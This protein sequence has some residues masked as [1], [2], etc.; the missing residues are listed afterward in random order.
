[1]LQMW[2]QALKS[3]SA[4]QPVAAGPD[5]A[6]LRRL[7]AELAKGLDNAEARWEVQSA[8]LAKG[9]VDLLPQAPE[10]FLSGVAEEMDKLA[11]QETTQVPHDDSSAS[12]QRDNFRVGRGKAPSSHRSAPGEG[13]QPSAGDGS[14][15]GQQLQS[16]MKQSSSKLSESD[17][18]YDTLRA[19]Q[20]EIPPLRFGPG[21]FTDSSENKSLL[22]Q[23]AD[24][25]E[26]QTWFERI[27]R[28]RQ[29]V[30]TPDRL[31]EIVKRA[32][33]G[34]ALE[35]TKDAKR[36]A[37]AVNRSQMGDDAIRH[38]VRELNAAFDR[39]R[40]SHG[41]ALSS[42]PPRFRLSVATRRSKL[43]LDLFEAAA[44]EEMISFKLF[45]A[46]IRWDELE[47]E[48]S[49]VPFVLEIRDALIRD[50]VE[51][52]ISE[53]S[54]LR[55]P[56]T[57]NR[58]VPMW[59]R[60]LD[61]VVA[62]VILLNAVSM[63]A[64]A[65]LPWSGWFYV[66]F[67][68]T[69]FF[70]FEIAV[71][72]RISGIRRYCIGSMSMW[73]WFDV[74]VVILA[75][76]DMAA[77]FIAS[78]EQA[79]NN[80]LVF[81]VARLARLTKMM[82]LLRLLRLRIFKELALMVKGVIAG[83]RTL[84]WAIVL[85]FFVTYAIGVILRQTV[86]EDKV[87]MEDKYGTVLFH[88]MQWSMFMV[89]RCFTSDCVL[90]DGSPLVG[91]LYHLYGTF[92]LMSYC[93]S[94]IF[95]AFGIFNLIAAT[96]VE[97][98]ME[99]ARQKRQLSSEEEAA[100]VFI[101]L[102]QLILKFGGAKALDTNELRHG[103]RVKSEIMDVVGDSIPVVEG[104]DASCGDMHKISFQTGGQVTRDD[105][106]LVLEDQEVHNLLDDL[107]V[108]VADRMEL[109]DVI[110][111]DGNGN[112]EISELIL[113]ILKLRSGGADKSDMVATIL[114]IRSIQKNTNFLVD[115]LQ[116]VRDLTN[117]LHK[118]VEDPQKSRVPARG[119]QDLVS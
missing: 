46:L 58:L 38:T 90:P 76:T 40:K 110:D 60:A 43:N 107:E 24:N 91:H 85:L 112:I 63:G 93:I 50:S 11:A 103:G 25:E 41:G 70:C 27:D 35:N 59:Q 72:V 89:F 74:A 69:A 65:D 99:A 54:H 5:F 47:I 6:A 42:S 16:A 100:R 64:A 98:V 2:C 75:V 19:S 71:K 61:P 106:N 34:R 55:P 57:N 94:V 45:C 37:K 53:Y 1:M 62:I 105:F 21:D 7:V 4:G 109:F 104:K 113:G 115:M 81:R 96:F 88:S 32:R 33:I 13:Q 3:S 30:L 12:S 78:G 119:S 22:E 83:L 108:H 39:E 87:A 86:G 82:R 17:A 31:A 95:V 92:F 44:P 49:M 56:S 84:F 18:K 15:P 8:Q 73:N 23:H 68:F 80:I 67:L 77:W 118:E 116:E 51:A 9:I 36:F 28:D 52:M 48:S 79:L 111:A 10:P 101:K 114:G 26:L 14:P 66:E 102:R 20:S 29:G 117:T 97:T